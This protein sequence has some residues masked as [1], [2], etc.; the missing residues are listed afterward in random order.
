MSQEEKNK[1]IIL[2]GDFIEFLRTHGYPIGVDTHLK[3]NRILERVEE[4][5]PAESLK[6]LLSPIFANSSQQQEDFYQLFDSFFE[7]Y[8]SH[9]AFIS[10]PPDPP[11]EDENLVRR[12]G[13]LGI[14]ARR[15]YYLSLQIILVLALGFIGVQGIDCYI[16]TGRIQGAAYCVLGLNDP[17]I[18]PQDTL[19][20]TETPGILEEDKNDPNLTTSDENPEETNDQSLSERLP[21][22]NGKPIGEDIS[23][24]KAGIFQ[25]Y[26]PLVKVLL[27]VIII[28]AFLFYE[29][30]WRNKRKFFLLKE[31]SK[32]PPFIWTINRDPKDFK[33]YSEQ[34][35]F[36]ASRKLREREPVQSQELDLDKT[37]DET[38]ETGGYPSLQFK[39]K[40]RPPEYLVLIEKQ[41]TRDHQAML[42]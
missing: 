38:L 27:I 24:L 36:E 13:M 42:F 5:F 22:E 3:I 26:G 19:V 1:Q 14:L 41:S 17:F 32:S 7:R 34:Q 40:S 25:Q 31:R 6:T 11:S 12:P 23:D 35:F 4:G 33:L 18:I 21:L 39:S 10:P 9:S 37:I 30:Y 28:T 29:F 2:F 20:V 16:K 8:Q 15:R